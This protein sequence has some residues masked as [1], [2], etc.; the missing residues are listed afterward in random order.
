MYPKQVM[1]SCL[2]AASRCRNPRHA[3]GCGSRRIYMVAG[4]PAAGVPACWC[5]PVGFEEWGVRVT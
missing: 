4:M 5:W 3:T 1:S 2:L